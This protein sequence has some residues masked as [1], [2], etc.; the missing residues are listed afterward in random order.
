MKA[1]LK[2]DEMPENCMQCELHVRGFCVPIVKDMLD[3]YASRRP[4]CPL[5]PVKEKYPEKLN[6]GNM[7]VI[8]DKNMKP[9]EWKLVQETEI[10]GI[11]KTN[12]QKDLWEG[13]GFEVDMKTGE[14]EPDKEDEKE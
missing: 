10:T 5:K 1:Y 12:L 6:L 8:V 9:G 11:P 4:D 7:R 14:W 3:Y 2:I 13:K